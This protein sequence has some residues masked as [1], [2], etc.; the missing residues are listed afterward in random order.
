MEKDKDFYD[1]VYSQPYDCQRY[2]P[3]YKQAVNLISEDEHV[4][5]Y[6]CGTGH[7][8]NLLLTTHPEISYT[9]F[10]FSKEALRQAV[11]LFPNIEKHLLLMDVK[12]ATVTSNRF[13]IVMLEVLEHIENDFE[14]I[15]SLPRGTRIIFSLPN[16]DSEAHVRY[17]ERSYEIHERYSNL[18]EMKL[19]TMCRMGSE[20]DNYIYLLEGRRL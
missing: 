5:E 4:I 20:G 3:V 2:Y 6:G 10:D 1:M 17:F 12:Q 16:F 14:L 15:V 8:A 19:V 9:G 7:F 18:I 13:T 11:A